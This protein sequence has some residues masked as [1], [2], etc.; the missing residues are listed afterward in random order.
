MENRNCIK[1]GANIAAHAGAGRPKAYCSD[2]CRR[3][4]DLEI[5]RIDRRMEKLEMDAQN[6]RLG[7]GMFTDCDA[8]KIA[9]EIEQNEARLKLLL[10]GND[11]DG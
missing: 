5:R 2:A 10:S 11:G 4:A 8:E 7:R 3:S 6:L 9:A 1:C